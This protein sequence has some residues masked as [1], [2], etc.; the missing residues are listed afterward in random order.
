[1]ARLP[2]AIR[3]TSQNGNWQ[4]ANTPARLGYF[5]SL[6]APVDK[7]LENQSRIRFV[8]NCLGEKKLR[9]RKKLASVH[10]DLSC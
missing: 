3:K 6:G 4:R 8:D 7:V 5:P 1:M 9:P 2:R 10:E